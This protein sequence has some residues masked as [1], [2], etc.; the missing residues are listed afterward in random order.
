MTTSL[1]VFNTL[2]GKKEPFTPID[3]K[4]V[5]IYACGPTVYD[6]SH[7]GHARMAITWDVIQRYLRF[8]GYN[9]IFVRDIT[10][11]DDKII[12]R[13]G[14]LGMRPEQVAREYTFEFWRDIDR[15]S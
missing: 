11:V 10:D 15:K 6:R 12:K 5:R 9:V 14:E 2:T 13:A 3:G 7:L 1:Q 4:T 8:I